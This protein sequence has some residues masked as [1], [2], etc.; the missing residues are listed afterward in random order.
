[1]TLVWKVN[2]F[3]TTDRNKGNNVWTISYFQKIKKINPCAGTRAAGRIRYFFQPNKAEWANII[4]SA[5]LLATTGYYASSFIILFI[6][7]APVPFVFL[8]HR[9]NETRYMWTVRTL[10]AEVTLL[11][12]RDRWTATLDS[13]KYIAATRPNGLII[14]I[15]RR[16]NPG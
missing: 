14:Y 8:P 9:K 5:S 11:E 4:R 1:M 3:R 16:K 15:L 10:L 6:N 7:S 2:S 13:G 12:R